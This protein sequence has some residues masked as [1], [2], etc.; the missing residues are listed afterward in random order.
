MAVCYIRLLYVMST[1]IVQ[2]EISETAKCCVSCFVVLQG[3][4]RMNLPSNRERVFPTGGEMFL[5]VTIL[6]A[7][8]LDTL[9]TDLFNDSNAQVK[10]TLHFIQCFIVSLIKM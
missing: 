4:C 8:K 6:D 7:Y 5:G 9:T 10:I 2:A 1:A 3:I